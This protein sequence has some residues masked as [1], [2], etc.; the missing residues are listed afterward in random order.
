MAANLPARTLYLGLGFT[1][2]GLEKDA[3]RIDG[4]SYDD[5]LLRLDLR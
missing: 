4:Q 1:V 3:L 5:E 2:F